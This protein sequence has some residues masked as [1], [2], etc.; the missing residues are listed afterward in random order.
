M[1]PAAKT[2]SIQPVGSNKI[3]NIY[4]SSAKKSTSIGST[5]DDSDQS[6]NDSMAK[7]VS[8][9]KDDFNLHEMETQVPYGTV[10]NESIDSIYTANTQLPNGCNN[11]SPS[12]HSLDTQMPTETLPSVCKINNQQDMQ[13]DLF[14]ANKENDNSIFNAETQPCF[15]EK[16]H[17]SK[18]EK[19]R[20]CEAEDRNRNDESQKSSNLSEE[21]I[22][23]TEVDEDEFQDDFNSQ[24]L[25]P[26]S[27]KGKL[28]LKPPDNEIQVTVK[29]N[30]RE[31]RGKSD[32]STDCEDIEILPTQKLTEKIDDDLTDCEDDNDK[33]V[34]K[35]S[36]TN[37]PEME[38]EDMLTQII[39]EDVVP[40]SS[41]NIN[42]L[43]TKLINSKVDFE[44]MLTQVIEE[45]LP[46]NS[47]DGKNEHNDSKVNSKLASN[48]PDVNIEDMLTQVIEDDIPSS[49]KTLDSLNF[50]EMPTQV[51]CEDNVKAKT[52]V[53]HVNF[54]DLPTQI[55]D[56]DIP[57][58]KGF[59]SEKIKAHTISTASPFKIP[60]TSPI[61]VKRK[62]VK[63]TPKETTLIA[64]H[65]NDPLNID[66]DENYY[67]ATQDIFDDLCTQQ[68]PS[69]DKQKAKSDNLKENTDLDDEIVPCSVEEEITEL[70]LPGLDNDLSPKKIPL[71]RKDDCDKN[72][73]NLSA[74]QIREVIGVDIVKRHPS[75]SSDVDVTPKKLRPNFMETDLPNSQE[76]KC[77]VTCNSKS[78]A[79]ESSSA[80]ESE[81]DSQE[82]TPIL[83]RK[84]KKTKVDAKIDLTKKFV[85]ALPARIITRIRKPTS[86]LQGADGEAKKVNENIL[87]PKFLVE[88]EGDMNNEIIRENILR[89]KSSVNDKNKSKDSSSVENLKVNTC[90]IEKHDSKQKN[91]KNKTVTPKVDDIII[92]EEKASISKSSRPL[93]HKIEEPVNIIVEPSKIS[94]RSTRKR[95]T[96]DKAIDKKSV[97]VDKG[98]DRKEESKS[99]DKRSRRHEQKKEDKANSSPEVKEVRRSR[100]QRSYKEK[101]KDDS[102]IKVKITKPPKKNTP[103]Q[104][105]AFEQSAVYSIS[106]D[107]GPDTP[108]NLKRPASV[109]LRAPSPKRTRSTASINSSSLRSTPARPLKTQYVLFTAFPSNEVRAKI[110]ELGK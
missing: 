110:E 1:K 31:S 30:K 101:K 84:K 82:S 68:E 33:K 40:T 10:H 54:E 93:P 4:W 34:N 106:S 109:S 42:V 5:F 105:V 108:K 17:V 2:I 45:D 99:K 19:L 25:L 64:N 11:A 95:H 51:I 92:K 55:L 69:I 75:D 36:A 90:K 86:K 67:A 100:R 50:E 22:L 85:D 88:Q 37:I 27:P 26:V 16:Q 58:K 18:E 24:S 32:S 77:S 87:K 47:K 97:S 35:P 104:P 78:I 43:K 72:V 94:T 89:L 29:P 102:L 53:Q 7:P 44:E 39:D 21:E 38:F 71:S 14:T 46:P 65:L 8:N 3:D 73:F 62:D 49:K 103:V 98:K 20:I 52:N 60:M 57:G 66:S 91:E 61:K 96:S 6:L 28:S 59:V 23:F 48:S 80:S 9:V 12:I 74:Q 83:F 63:V 15:P 81:N 41:A 13:F 56:N 107:S 76:I 79:T 70:R